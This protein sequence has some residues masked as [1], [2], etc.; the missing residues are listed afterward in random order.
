M[1]VK[2]ARVLEVGSGR[3]GG[4]RYIAPLLSSR[5]RW[6]GLDYSPDT[7][8]LAKRSEHG[9]TAQPCLSRQGDAEHLPFADGSFDI[10]VNIESSHCY[11]DVERLCP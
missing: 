8:R 4:S 3:G 11:A 9:D 7:V 10:V 6:S 5:P 2:G 1:P